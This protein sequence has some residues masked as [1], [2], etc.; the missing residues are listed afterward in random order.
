MQ[1]RYLREDRQ[2]RNEEVELPLDY[3]DS[4][5][6]SSD[7]FDSE[8]DETDA[9]STSSE[10][11]EHIPEVSVQDMVDLASEIVRGMT[12]EGDR[13]VRFRFPQG[14]S[15]M[16]L[17][18]AREIIVQHEQNARAGRN[19]GSNVH[20]DLGEGHG[21]GENYYVHRVNEN[22]EED[23]STLRV[24]FGDPHNHGQNAT[25]GEG[26]G[27]RPFWLELADFI[28]VTLFLIVLLRLIR[29]ALSVTSFSTDILQDTFDFVDQVRREAVK[30][31]SG[32]V[33]SAGE[34]ISTGPL[35][36]N[37]TGTNITTN[38]VVV[39]STMIAKN[40][41]SLIMKF[42]T[43]IHQ[44]FPHM[45]PSLQVFFTVATFYAYTVMS[46]GF[47]ICS[48]VFSMFCL[49]LSI[50]KR[51]QGIRQFV[52]SVLRDGSQCI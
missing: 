17:Q 29:N 43:V 6:G 20:H 19:T 27:I 12:N 7:S 40:R 50:G 41:S 33:S 14:R 45:G 46:S 2:L 4:F 24:T 26:R 37:A 9:T 10:S 23:P 44:T 28:T 35:V 51:W 34:N 31:T 36:A 25:G 30:V 5:S 47:L 13:T 1:R 52:V 42:G 22:G 49:V 18:T 16:D 3:E 32:N 39:N 48:L 8:T 21:I 15:G 38:N 11:S